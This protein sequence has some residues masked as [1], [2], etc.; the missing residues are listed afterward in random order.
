MY[1]PHINKGLTKTEKKK[2]NISN[3]YEWGYAYFNVQLFI[4]QKE[5]AT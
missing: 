5:K 1:T 4:I 3:S 2:R